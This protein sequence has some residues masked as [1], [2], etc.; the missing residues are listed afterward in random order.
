LNKSD[1]VSLPENPV[2]FPWH[3]TFILPGDKTL[4][5]AANPDFYG[6]EPWLS[7]D[8]STDGIDPVYYL[9]SSHWPQNA[10]PAT[11]ICF[12]M[13]GEFWEVDFWS[14]LSKLFLQIC[15][16]G[17]RFRQET[18]LNLSELVTT[19]ATA[20]GSV[21]LILGLAFGES[22]CELQSKA[23]E[24]VA[25]L[26]KKTFSQL[27]RLRKSKSLVLEGILSMQA[28]QP[29]TDSSGFIEGGKITNIN[30]NIYGMPDVSDDVAL[31]LSR[32]GLFLQDP[33]S[34]SDGYFYENP[35]CLKLPEH[36]FPIEGGVSSRTPEGPVHDETRSSLTGLALD[37]TS[38]PADFENELDFD[39]LLD[40][41]AQHDY[42][43]QAT[44]D[45]RIKTPL[46]EWVAPVGVL[47][48]DY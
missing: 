7:H 8:V 1:F 25:T 3:D 44:V 28:L 27:T 2:D 41:F 33:E 23:G 18:A 30:L 14:K 13:V 24:C 15:D 48:A 12:G 9:G 11:A 45:P 39:L 19:R 36:A 46:L 34:L 37:E 35:Q 29:L 47:A 10:M 6:F 31:E 43:V 4:L 32:S 5:E 26:N 20:N 16:I 17:I 40:R 22:R 38:V 21:F 42:L